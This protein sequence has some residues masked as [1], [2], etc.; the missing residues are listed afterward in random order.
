MYGNVLHVRN[1]IIKA[2]VLRVPRLGKIQRGSESVRRGH[3]E[4]LWFSRERVLVNK[5]PRLSLL[6]SS[7]L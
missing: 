5:P 2:I 3:E 1:A 6:L 7:L 4:L